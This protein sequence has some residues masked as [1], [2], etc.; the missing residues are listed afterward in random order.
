MVCIVV[1]VYFLFPDLALSLKKKWD[2]GNREE[3]ND[4]CVLA[5]EVLEALTGTA[6][7]PGSSQA[8]Y[9]QDHVVERPHTTSLL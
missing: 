7:I 6:V 1:G 8:A 3:K 4:D 9:S 2:G 5:E